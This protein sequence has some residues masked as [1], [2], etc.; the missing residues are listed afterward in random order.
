MLSRGSWFAGAIPLLL[1][2]ILLVGPPACLADTVNGGINKITDK[3]ESFEAEG[4]WHTIDDTTNDGLNGPWFDVSDSGTD[5]K[6]SFDIKH[7]VNHWT[8]QAAIGVKVVLDGTHEQGPHDA[9]DIDP[10]FLDEISS[11]PIINIPF[12]VLG[13]RNL[14]ASK[15]VYH[16][17]HVG[18][19][20]RDTYSFKAAVNSYSGTNNKVGGAFK[21]GAKHEGRAAEPPAAPIDMGFGSGIP[22]GSTVTFDAGTGAL[23]LAV[24]GINILDAVGG[25]SGGID[26]AYAADPFLGGVFTITD[27]HYLG[28]EPDGRYRFSGCEVSVTDPLAKFNFDAGF[29]DY[30][31]EST[32]MGAA[33][34]SFA[35]YDSLAIIDVNDPL[36]DPSLFLEEFV[37]LNVMG[38]GYSESEWVDVYGVMLTFYTE[39]D[40]VIATN[41]FTESAS[42]PAT[43]TISSSR[44]TDTVPAF[45]SR[46]VILLPLAL[47]AA[48]IALMVRRA[49]RAGRA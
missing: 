33:A 41:G 35:L 16:P 47:A 9:V 3:K 22:S 26:P 13:G 49:R 27:M 18:V 6:W 46:G 11:K 1:L 42:L 34:S 39:T 5:D 38:L 2:V 15:T 8:D 23:T 45:S 36:E 7:V 37:N 14:S 25:L 24:T 40:L 32:V 28:Q 17:T 20:H 44:G 30:L 10:N 48:V 4:W 12:V 21:I 29:E 31:I 43:A 19:K